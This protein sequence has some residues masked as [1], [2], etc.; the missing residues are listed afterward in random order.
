MIFFY[1]LLG[2]PTAN[3][4]LGY[5][6]RDRLTNLMLV[7]PVYYSTFDPKVID[8]LVDL[9]PRQAERSVGFKLAAFQF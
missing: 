6:Q 3:F 8:N 7:I 4:A 2:S 1:L 9:F 5:R